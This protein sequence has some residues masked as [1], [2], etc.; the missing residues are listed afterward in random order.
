VFRAVRR[1][2]PLE[3]ADL[4]ALGGLLPDHVVLA[5]LGAGDPAPLPQPQPIVWP[6][7]TSLAV[8]VCGL[9]RVNS[10]RQRIDPAAVLPEGHFTATERGAV[11]SWTGLELWLQANLPPQGVPRVAALL[12]LDDCD[13][14]IGLFAAAGRIMAGID[15]PVILMGDTSGPAPRLRTAY[16][17]DE[18]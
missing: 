9:D 12:R 4:D 16:R 15:V 2:G 5:E 14:A 10:P 13:D 11:W 6:V 1:G 3:V 7:R 8:V 17:L 18:A